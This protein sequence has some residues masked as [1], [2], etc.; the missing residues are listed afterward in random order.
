MKKIIN[1]LRYDTDKATLVGEFNN[2]GAGASSTTDFQYWEA[3]LYKTPRSGKYFLAGE[4]GPMSR[5]G[6]QHDQN[7]RGWGE[8]IMPMDKQ[9]AFEWAQRF[10]EPGIVEI[11]FADM[12]EDA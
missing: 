10:L 7:T 8:K 3:A 1:G 2:I 4:G 6:S 12:V 5:F 11:E 9:E